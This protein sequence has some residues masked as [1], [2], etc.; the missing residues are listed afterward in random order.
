MMLA[1]EDIDTFYGETQVLFGVSL[2]GRPGRGGGAARAQRRRQDDDAALYPRA[3]A[4]AHRAHPLRRPRHHRTPTHEIA[5][6]GIGWVP[7]DRRI[8]PTLTVERNLAIAA[9]A[10]A[11]APG[12]RSEMLRDLH[13]AGVPAARAS[14]RTSRA[15]RCRW[16]PSRARCGLAGAGAVRRAEPGPGAEDRAGRDAHIRRLKERGC[17]C[18]SSSRTRSPR[19]RSPTA[20]TSWTSDASCTPGPAQALR[21]DDPPLRRGCSGSE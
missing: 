2:G 9:S 21:D 15:A 20:S 16:S 1:L 18:C 11:S 10:R 17:R 6:A 7:D 12:A 8:F 14:A 19:W 3:H 5:R 13:G 4:R